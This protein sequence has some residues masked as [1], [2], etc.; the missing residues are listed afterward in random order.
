MASHAAGSRCAALRLAR[1][2][3]WDS[4]GASTPD[5][6]A[7]RAARLSA[8]PP[9]LRPVRCGSTS[10]VRPHVLVSMASEKLPWIQGVLDFMPELDHGPGNS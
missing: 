10:A 2:V 1:A 6:Q 3:L 8:D 9:T 5:S 4:P 7:A